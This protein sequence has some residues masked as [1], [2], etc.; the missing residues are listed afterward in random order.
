VR[1]GLCGDLA[2]S[3]DDRRENIRRVG[4]VAKLFVETGVIV[5]TAFISPFRH[6]RERVR[7]MLG[8][9]DFIEVYCRC[10]LEVCE[11]R[12]V[13][14]LYKKARQ[15][16]IR[17]FTGISS[18]YE[19]PEEPALSINTAEATLEDSVEQVLA[20]L[21]ER[22]KCGAPAAMPARP[23]QALSGHPVLHGVL[24]A[25][26]GATLALAAGS[27]FAHEKSS[28]AD[29]KPLQSMNRG[30]KLAPQLSDEFDGGR[31]DAAKWD[32]DVPDWGVWSWEPENVWVDNGY[33]NVRMEYA[34][35]QRG[36]QKLY[37]KS[38]IIKS[39]ARPIR[40]GYF[41]ARI[42]A[43][44]R[45]PGVAP[46]FWAY[47]QE[48]NEWTEID[49]AEL[50]QRRRDAR[51]IDTNVHVFRQASFPGT[52]PLQEER[53][54]M[55]PWDPRDDFHVYGCEWGEKE[56]VWYIDG[57]QVQARRNDYWHQALD[58][59]ISFGVRGELKKLASPDGFPTVFEVD[60]VRVWS[61]G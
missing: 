6:D 3:E 46:A 59:V 37:Y 25:L 40:Y 61:R 51:L 53:T 50:T 58:V 47:R 20:L 57:Q 1:H 60:Y 9:A 26:M 30:W 11:E 32:N 7:S 21:A 13:K 45:Y 22:G 15:G 19:E 39:K 41:E 31:L 49:F 35:H 55:A 33:L 43:A 38:G 24:A 28:V 8:D 42:K 27:V 4:E 18:P 34:E 44:S 29:A 2:F 12:D 54:W 36:W 16:L 5:L 56:I 23:A 14:G 52:L 10:P 48:E 17:D